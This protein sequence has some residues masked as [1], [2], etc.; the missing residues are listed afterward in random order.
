MR[1]SP[2]YVVYKIKVS[3][4]LFDRFRNCRHY[5]KL[6]CCCTG[7]TNKILCQRRP[8]GLK[9][10]LVS[11][12]ET[13]LPGSPPH[14]IGGNPSGGPASI[15]SSRF[16]QFWQCVSHTLG[17][18]VHF[19]LILGRSLWIKGGGVSPSFINMAA[20]VQK[21]LGPTCCLV[22]VHHCGGPPAYRSSSAPCPLL[23]HSMWPLFLLFLLPGIILC[24]Q[25]TSCQYQLLASS[26]PCW[27]SQQSQIF[28]VEYDAYM[29]LSLN[30]I[31][32]G[33]VTDW[34]VSSL[35]Q[36]SKFYVSCSLGAQW[37]MQ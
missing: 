8:T 13:P 2:T 9:Q 4:R 1:D 14:L 10:A 36:E 31:L 33:S 17:L 30:V 18:C 6:P 12:L 21:G 25:A 29:H 20:E 27:C 7:E 37:F 23:P 3:P 34:Y 16:I 32:R 26:G 5:L 15:T 11:S 35:L 24:A 22:M 28:P 19:H